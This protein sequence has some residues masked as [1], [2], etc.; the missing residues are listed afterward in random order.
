[1]S[2]QHGHLQYQNQYWACQYPERPW[3][4]GC[5]YLIGCEGC[6]IAIRMHGTTMPEQV[7]MMTYD[8][9][10]N[11]IHTDTWEQAAEVWNQQTE[12]LRARH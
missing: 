4:T 7:H 8:R 9:D 12:E 10:H 5:V 2:Q 1:M 3:E 11:V 6:G